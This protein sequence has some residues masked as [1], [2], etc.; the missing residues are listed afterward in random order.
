[1]TKMPPIAVAVFFAAV[2]HVAFIAIVSPHV[3]STS[4]DHFDARQYRGLAD[5]VLAG[6]GFELEDQHGRRPNLS[7]TPVYPLFV[8]L[9]GAGWDKTLRVVAAQHVLI[10][11]TAALIYL[12]MRRRDESATLATV[13]FA[14][15]AFDLTT[16]TYASYLLTE[17]LFTFLLWAAFF[18]WP[19]GTDDQRAG[20]GRSASAGLLWGLATLAR[21]ISLYILPGFVVLTGIA[22]IRH[23]VIWKRTT[24]VVL[25][26][27]LTVGVWFARNH[28]VSGHY[29]FSTIEGENLL[30]YRAAL[31]SLPDGLNVDDWRKELREKSDE[32][33]Y[34]TS[35]PR[36]LAE[37]DLAK[38]EL[39]V[40][41]VRE[42]PTGIVRLYTLGL[43]R[44]FVSPNRT[45]FFNLIGAGHAAWSL[46]DVDGEIDEDDS[47]SISEY[48][49]LIASSGYQ[50]VLLLLTAVGCF[51]A[52]RERR[53]DFFSLV[54]LLGYL[55]VF[56][57]GL[58]THARFRVPL[59]PGMAVL[60]A[61]GLPILAPLMTALL[62]RAPAR[63]DVL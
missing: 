48:P 9:F 2:V 41:L 34:D 55:T 6:N 8:A 22:G 32:G 26:G 21:P 53:W 47:I 56:S 39:A 27:I 43:P 54:V 35:I 42:N 59:I 19:T 11:A 24:V 29:V 51:R 20:W 12:W 63:S 46:R 36:E 40:E 45:Y 49:Y 44:L 61:Y 18:V 14:I 58:E 57:C 17:T 16:M 1:M 62:R 50:L 15:V 28:F 25:V 4:Q 52:I 23:R 31:V 30:H 10:L 60:A 13:A 5:S 7:R 38:K 37:L 33:S 3:V